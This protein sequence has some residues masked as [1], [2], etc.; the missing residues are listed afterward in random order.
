MFADDPGLHIGTSSWSEASWVGAFYPAGM[1]AR[2]FLGHYARSFD[3]VEIDAT[4]YAAPAPSTVQGWRERTPDA[5]RF[6]AKV[7]R[8]ITHE[9]ALVDAQDDMARF[10]EVMELLGPKRGPL[11]LQFPFQPRSAFPE[12]GPFLERLDGFLAGLPGDFRYVVEVRNRDW[13][14][15]PL[16]E[17]CRRHRV[18]LAWTDQAWMPGPRGWQRKCPLATTDF[19]Y[20]RWLGDYRAMEKRTDRWDRTLVDRRARVTEWLPVLH[21]LRAA[22]V[23]VYGYFNNHFAGHAPA[24][25]ELLDALLR[26]S[27]PPAQCHPV[28]PRWE[29]PDLPF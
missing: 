17:L 16:V 7:P 5:F 23:D 20:L 28:E 11:L 18:A 6:A 9:R 14:D 22:R 21:A 12:A 29:T 3:T 19:A 25:I 27:E 24:S 26:G 15:A 10:L 4:F 1:A 8:T 13:L 2:D